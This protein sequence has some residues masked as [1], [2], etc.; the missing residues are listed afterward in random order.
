MS[1][2]ILILMALVILHKTSL[3]H[4][5]SGASYVDFYINH[6]SSWLFLAEM[7]DLYFHVQYIVNVFVVC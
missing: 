3:T 4:A 7:A 2:Y 1:L 5:G 6:L